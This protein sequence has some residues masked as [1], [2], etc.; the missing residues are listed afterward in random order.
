MAKSELRGLQKI[1]QQAKSPKDLPWYRPEPPEML[2]R[3]VKERGARRGRA[4][5]LGCGAGANSIYLAKHGYDVT[6]VDYLPEAIKMAQ[7]AAREDGATP[8]LVQA[9]LLTWESDGMFDLVLDSGCLHSLSAGE[10]P[11][12][13]KRLL[14]WLGHAADYL[15]IHFS[16][17]HPLDWRPI[18]PRR[19]KRAQIV[20]EFHPE[21]L[22]RIYA[23]DI[24]RTPFPIGPKV[25]IST[26]WFRRS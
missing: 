14:G 22:L 4:L 26:Y 19:R 5:D 13:K 25:L 17:R 18:G 6:G 21:L 24:H 9:D 11:A 7:A 15:L 16:K 1:Y 12:Y 8:K 10:R 2:Q 3:L 23:E 20:D